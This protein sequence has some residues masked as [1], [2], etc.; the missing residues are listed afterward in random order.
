MRLVV[1]GVPVEPEESEEPEEPEVAEV[2][3]G[4]RVAKPIN[5]T[6]DV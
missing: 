6:I 5:R 4:L 1:P 2:P 3:V